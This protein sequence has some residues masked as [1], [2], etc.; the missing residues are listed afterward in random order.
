MR[1]LEDFLKPA[2]PPA[3]KVITVGKLPKPAPVVTP[4]AIPPK[5]PPGGPPRQYGSNVAV[6][7][8]GGEYAGENQRGVEYT[9]LA[10]RL[11]YKVFVAGRMT[12]GP[13][14]EVLDTLRAKNQAKQQYGAN[15]IFSANLNED[16]AQ[17]A[18]A[19]DWDNRAM[20]WVCVP[21]D[22]K[23]AKQSV[24]YSHVCRPGA[25]HHSSL[26]AGRE[27]LGGGE[28]IVEEGSLKKISANSGHY[29]PGLTALHQCVLALAPAW[30]ADTTV[31]LWN[32]NTGLW[33][34]VP[35]N[36]FATDPTGGGTYKAHPLS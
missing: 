34:D 7:N 33:E 18:I 1:F 12:R 4:P 2:P 5:A 29:Q 30:Q 31:F 9:P 23:D 8:K 22:A 24:F 20:I 6:H 21:V 13:S 27:I 10:Q 17:Q 15:S 11:L 36:N 25:F 35:V 16:P 3:P 32:R 19:A 26:A 28:W 14:S